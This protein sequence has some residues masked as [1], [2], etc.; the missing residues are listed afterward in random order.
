MMRK[1][2]VL[3]VVVAALPFGS[4][5]AQKLYKWVDQ[6]GKVSYHDRPP[7][8]GS[9]YQVEE[10]NVSKALR[11]GGDAANRAPVVLYSVPKCAT[12]DL[13]R[14]YLEKHKIPF[15]E[16]NVEKDTKLQQELKSKAGSL[17][18][19][20]ILVGNKVL[21]GYLESLLEGELKAAGYLGGEPAE[22]ESASAGD[23]GSSEALAPTE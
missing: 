4:A 13:A 17:S 5:S 1:L 23:T 16:R 10:K 2:I 15:S 20:T 8:E 3:L 22:S 12:C 7:P 14:F 11:G 18:V 9:Q 21:N 6:D 19:P